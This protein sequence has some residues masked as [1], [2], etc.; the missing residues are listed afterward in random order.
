VKVRAG[1]LEVHSVKA[2]ANANNGRDY[3]NG[4]TD[5]KDLIVG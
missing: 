3:A 5:D 1:E 2:V 4:Y